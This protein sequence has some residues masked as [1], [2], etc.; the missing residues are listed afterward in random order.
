[1]YH[2]FLATVMP[3]DLELTQLGWNDYQKLMR[4][5]QAIW[6]ER[7]S[8][9]GKNTGRLSKSQLAACS[10]EELVK[11]LGEREKAVVVAKTWNNF[12]SALGNEPAVHAKL[13][14]LLG[15]EGVVG[16]NEPALEGAEKDNDGGDSADGISVED[17]CKFQSNR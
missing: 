10:M 7:E 3:P 13:K 16:G 1:M 2:S 5:E 8:L 15:R 14:E 4:G 9:V 6:S 17:H 11:L 12:Q